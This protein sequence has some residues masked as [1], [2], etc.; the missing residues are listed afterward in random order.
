MGERFVCYADGWPYRVDELVLR[1]QPAGIL[2]KVLQDREALGP[3]LHLAIIRRERQPRRRSSVNPAKRST[4]SPPACIGPP[5]DLDRGVKPISSLLAGFC[6][7]LSRHG[8]ATRLMLRRPSSSGPEGLSMWRIHGIVAAVATALMSFAPSMP[9]NAGEPVP[10]LAQ[11]FMI[12]AADP[13]IKL[14]IVNKH[15]TNLRLSPEKILLFV[16][17]ATQPAEATFDLPLEGMSWMDYIARHGWD[18]YLVDVRGYGRSTRPAE[19]RPACR[20]QS[21]NRQNRCRNP[22]RQFRD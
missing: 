4:S 15:P 7:Q 18:V 14:Y 2:D 9:T 5:A 17:G 16:H 8:V 21:S 1:N 11:E 12:D 6:T 10:V 20:E 13:G 22:R 3:Q 19:M